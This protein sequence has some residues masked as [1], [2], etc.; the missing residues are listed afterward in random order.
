MSG[1]CSRKFGP[2]VLQRLTIRTRIYL[3]ATVPLL[4]FLASAAAIWYVDLQSQ[5][6]SQALARNE[7][8][9]SLIGEFTSQLT[10]L[11]LRERDFLL[12]TEAYDAVTFRISAA[13][14]QDILGRMIGTVDE[15]EP[16]LLLG[17]LRLVEETFEDVYALRQRLGL[18]QANG[19]EKDLSRFSRAVESATEAITTIGSGDSGVGELR[20]IFSDMRETI[21]DYRRFGTPAKLQAFHAI[22][23]KFDALLKEMAIPPRQAKAVK[24]VADA[25]GSTFLAIAETSQALT[26]KSDTL[27]A[28]L[29]ALFSAAKRELAKARSDLSANREALAQTL[30]RMKDMMRFLIIGCALACVLLAFRIARSIASPIR[31]LTAAMRKLA[32][33]ETALALPGGSAKTEIGAMSQAIQVFLQTE[34]E[35][36]QLNLSQDQAQ[37]ERTRRAAVIEKEIEEFRADSTRV[38]AEIVGAAAE[39]DE[40]AQALHQAVIIAVSFTGEAKEASA[41]AALNV[42]SS[43]TAIEQLNSSVAEIAIQTARSKD[44][45][46]NGTGEA[47]RAQEIAREATA[48]AQEITGIVKLVQAIA[49]QTNL[50]AL[51]ATIE[52]ARA[53]EAGRGFAVVAA[54]V[55]N[56]AAE[57]SSAIGKISSYIEAVQRAAGGMDVANAS[58]N[59]LMERIAVGAASVF[60]SIDEQSVALQN[61][62][63]HAD[64]AFRATEKVAQSAATATGTIA[65][66]ENLADQVKQLSHR[67]EE[68]TRRMNQRVE[69]FLRTVQAA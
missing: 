59:E 27:R 62:A 55:K 64:K 14:T 13:L 56:L 37:I 67:M 65:E 51:N 48:S 66:T 36:Q 1:G 17:K 40:V 44:V 42:Q 35:K 19:L 63:E 57:T 34:Q 49:E 4:G 20:Q 52:A 8:R 10:D 26:A 18:R 45:A 12:N 61:V 43:A 39:L 38:L 29:I 3:L 69:G 23:E 5:Q 2:P 6:A 53:G 21:R 16:G 58:V 46:E 41:V 47:R 68:S 11:Q 31:M 50:L 32:M 28:S 60:A 9:S 33:G 24:D 15:A 25:Y 30:G 22:K 7:E 54:E